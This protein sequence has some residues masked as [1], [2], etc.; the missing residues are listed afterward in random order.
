MINTK[1]EKCIFKIMENNIQI[2]CQ[3]N[4]DKNIE[5]LENIYPPNTINKDKNTWLINNYYCR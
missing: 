5:K 4:I 1:C 3:Q 2:G